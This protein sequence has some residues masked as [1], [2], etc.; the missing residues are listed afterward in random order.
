MLKTVGAAP[1]CVALCKTMLSKMALGET[2][3]RHTLMPPCAAT[4]QMELH[5]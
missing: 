5:P 1:I 3:L 2:F 4:P